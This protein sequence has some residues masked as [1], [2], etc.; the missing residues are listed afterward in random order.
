MRHAGHE[1]APGGSRAGRGSRSPWG[2]ADG[3]GRMAPRQGPRRARQ[4]HAGAPASPSARVEPGREHLAVLAR[5]LVIEPR[6]R[7]L[8]RHRRSLLRRLEPPHRP[9]LDHHVH[10]PPRLG[11][12]IQCMMISAG[13]YYRAFMNSSSDSEATYP[14]LDIP[15]PVAE[16]VW[17]VDSGPIHVLGMP[18]PVRMTVVRLKG[19]DVWL[20]SPTRFSEPLKRELDGLGRIRHLIAPSIGHWTFLQEWQRACPEAETWA[21]P[22]LRQRTQVKKAGLRLDHDLGDAAPAAWADDIEQA[23]VPGA[24]GFREVD[25]LHKPT[26]TLVLTDLVVNLEAEKLP[27]LMRP[28]ARLVG[29]VAPE[30]T[31]PICV[32]WIVRMRRT[33]AA[34]ALTRLL[35]QDPERVVF[36]HGRWFER[37]G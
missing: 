30:G 17:I 28:A 36:S 7:L 37:D 34:A 27:W 26:R 22:E 24:A 19:G 16:G 12:C 14:P 4:S 5:Q 9:A 2:H 6:V 35:A 8:P 18:L 21:A 3:P 1:P 33:E 31:A 15:K 25:F 13:W 10:R 32:R 11:Q 23:V 20:H 29:G